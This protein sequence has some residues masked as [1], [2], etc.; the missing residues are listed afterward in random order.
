MR[1]IQWLMFLGVGASMIIVSCVSHPERGG[2]TLSK[3]LFIESG[4]EGPVHSRQEIHRRVKQIVAAVDDSQAYSNL[5]IT[6]PRDH[7]VFP[8]EMASPVF[9][10]EDNRTDSK[11]W[12]IRIEFEGRERPIH[13]LCDDNRWIPQDRAIWETIK[14]NSMGHEAVMTIFGLGGDDGRTVTSKGSVTISTST[15]KV[16]APIFYQQVPLPFGHAL[17]YSHLFRWRVGDVSSYE[18]PRIV[19]KNLPI[20][21]FCHSFS[22][23]GKTL[24]MDMDLGNDKGAYV[25]TS[26]RKIALVTEEDFI[27]WN[28]IRESDEVTNMGLFSRVSPDGNFVVS[29]VNDKPFMAVLDHADFSQLFF[30]ITGVLAYYAREEKRFGLLPGADDPHYVQTNPEWSPDGKHIVFCRAA[31]S[32]RL[33]EAMAEKRVLET[34]PGTDIHELNPM[35]PIQ[36]DLYRVPFNN[37]RGGQPE[38][39]PGASH[40]GRS[41]YFPRYSPDGKWIVFNQS[42]TGMV[43]QPTSQL[44]IMPAEGGEARRMGCN[45]EFYNSWHS[46]SPNGRWMV[47]TSKVNTPY[48]ELFISH[49]D[50]NGDA[51]PPVRLSRFSTPHF[52]A[53]IPEFVNIRPDALWEISLI[54]N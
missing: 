38:P 2:Q 3:S 20:C 30:P 51:S 32:R 48:T 4:Y 23:D 9:S 39:L 24:G 1:I 8:P 6:H 19:M 21:G 41:N 52:A 31:V 44:V 27:T 26:V 43:L 25:L 33:L 50:R 47:F 17:R 46:W 22:K 40:N 34:E 12:L 13:V 16:G 18:E 10:W 29:T 37:G 49:I 45:T 28:S 5:T 53:V 36:F 54:D 11:N 35:Y 7:A 42:E 15:D 14:A